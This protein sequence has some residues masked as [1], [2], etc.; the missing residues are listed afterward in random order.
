[1]MSPSQLLGRVI[2][3]VLSFF[4]LLKF[5]LLCFLEAVVVVLQQ[6]SYS[7][8]AYFIVRSNVGG[9]ITRRRLIALI[10]VLAVLLT[11]ATGIFLLLGSSPTLQIELDPLPPMTV[12]KGGNFSLTISVR[13][14]AGF[15]KPE[16]QDI[17]GELQLADGFIEESLQTNTRQLIYWNNKSRG[18]QSLRLN[19][20]CLEH[21]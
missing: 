6:F 3:V 15:F 16:L 8:T 2:F 11:T 14:S 4:H 19:H 1:M 10:A 12:K 17:Q 9:R 21:C 5:C 7:L 20:N 18:R 13:K